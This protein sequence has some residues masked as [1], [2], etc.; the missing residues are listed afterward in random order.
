MIVSKIMKYSWIYFPKTC[1][2]SELKTLKHCQH[3]FKNC[4]NG[5]MCN[6]YGLK[7]SLKKYI[8][9]KKKDISLP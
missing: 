5:E 1:K 3:K 2:T 8:S 4:I 6:V 9:S 7:D